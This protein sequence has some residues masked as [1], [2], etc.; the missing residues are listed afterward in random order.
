MSNKYDQAK[1]YKLTGNGLTYYGSTTQKYLSTR[2]AVHKYH[3]KYYETSGTCT[4]SQ[5]VDAP[6]CQISLVESFPCAN[7]NELRAR[8]RFWIENNA[9]VNK[10]IP[11]RT[12]QESNKI[13]R[14][15][16]KEKIA[17][18]KKNW[19]LQNKDKVAEYQRY[20]RARQRN[21]L[22]TETTNRPAESPF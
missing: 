11:G 12:R 6:D 22:P 2:L 16:N 13:Y 18:N 14:Q 19:D 21:K 8:E 9:C 20:Y 1:I 5:I 17:E 4:S 7:V 3:K 15:Q 10:Y